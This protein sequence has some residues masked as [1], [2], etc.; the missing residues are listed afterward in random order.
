MKK[1]KDKVKY[2][3][4]MDQKTLNSL[5]NA[6]KIDLT[7]KR[8]LIQNGCNMK[9]SKDIGI[10][11]LPSISTCLCANA[12]KNFC[13]SFKAER[14]YSN[15]R[16]GRY[17]NYLQSKKSNFEDLINSEIKNKNF[18]MIRWHE[19]GDVYSQEYLNK[20]Y[21]I[22]NKNPNVKFLLY[23]KTFNL[24]NYNNKP[25]NLSLFASL[26]YSNLNS[27]INLDLF[28]IATVINSENDNHNGYICKP[29]KSNKNYCG[30]YC[31]ICW[32]KK[33]NINFIKH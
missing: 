4:D 16:Q 22:C 17:T 6:N 7:K 24:F 18:K 8:K 13:Y 20:I 23:T 19:S 9:Y 5:Y 12:C 25:R 33:S 1:I 30:K 26:D 15:V 27:K 29:I 3:E 11:N 21:S 28:K 2:I 10:F 32:N 31:K 14:L